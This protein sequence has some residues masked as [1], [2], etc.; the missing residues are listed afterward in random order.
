VP[1]RRGPGERVRG[2]ETAVVLGRDGGLSSS[3]GASRRYDGQVTSPRRSGPLVLAL[4]LV[5]AGCGSSI[6][7][8]PA[9]SRQPAPTPSLTPVPGGA[10]AT[11]TPTAVPTSQ[12]EGFGT[13][14]D[15][16]PRSWPRLPGQSQSE[17][18]TDASEGL[19]VKGDTAA[20][21]RRLRDAL[22]QQGWTVDVGT[23]LEDGSIVLEATGAAAGCKAE[24]RFSAP[25][26]GD[27]IVSLLVYYGASCPFS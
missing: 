11:P 27:D 26:P 18:G 13:I 6:P 10:G 19:V 21:A 1:T 23:P 2:H 4:L 17:V 22:E 3:G 9:P 20:L 16:L 8:S 7:P 5:L 24:A 12:A 25:E 14:W 15:A